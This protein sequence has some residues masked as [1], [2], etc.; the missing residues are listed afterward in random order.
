[1][2]ALQQMK[3]P[4]GQVSMNGLRASVLVLGGGFAGLDTAIE[5]SQK[6][7]R[8]TLVSDRK[9]MFIYPTSIWMVT[10]EHR[11]ADDVIDLTETAAGY[12]FSFIQGTVTEVNPNDKSALV[13]GRKIA[14]DFL[15][16]AM[17]AGR[18]PIPG[19][20]HTLTVWGSPE[21]TESVNAALENL[22]AAG[23]GRIALGF[24]GNP[25]DGSA[26]RGGPLFEVLFN[27]DHML[28]KRKLRDRFELTF[29]APMQNPGA[30]MG[31]NAAEVIK[32]MLHRVGVKQLVGKRIVR[33]DERGVVFEG[34]T[35]LD[36]DLTIFIP[37]GT[38]HEAVKES[39]FPLNDSGFVTID[40][41][42]RVPGF[43]GVFAVGD[44]AALEGPEWRAKQ[45]HVTVA[46]AKTAVQAIVDSLKHQQTKVDYRDHV[47]IVCVMD[48]GNG[49]AFVKRT[50][51]KATLIFLPIIGHVLKKAWGLWYRFS[52]TRMLS[53]LLHRHPRALPVS[54]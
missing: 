10:G 46:M 41:R 39:S 35:R 26:V 7:L 50:E 48:T 15:V 43:D 29:F 3:S 47:N 51:K 36:A 1:M 27:I 32:T 53:R 54:P 40:G 24:G 9:E 25:K 4:D 11:R 13:D 30:K 18:L 14:A 12:G 45:G 28:R 8:V 19:M 5:L 2:A 23:G 21:D 33:F 6:G 34:E 44:V 16:L 31:P 49:A 22:I 37:A 20:S 52:H 38:G 17:G 42:C